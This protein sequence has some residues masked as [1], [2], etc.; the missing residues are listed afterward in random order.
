MLRGEDGFEKL[1]MARSVD[2]GGCG[3]ETE[4]AA[5]SGSITNKNTGLGSRLELVIGVGSK[6]WIT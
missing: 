2:T 5:L 6:P 1:N 4:V 3:I